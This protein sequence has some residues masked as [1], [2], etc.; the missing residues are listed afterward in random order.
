MYHLEIYWHGST[1][2]ICLL[3]IACNN[4]N[5]DGVKKVVPRLREYFVNYD[6]FSSVSSNTRTCTGIL[7]P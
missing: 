4:L 5:T 6:T 7:S 3:K 1:L 2:T